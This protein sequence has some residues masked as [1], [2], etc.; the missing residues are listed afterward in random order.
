MTWVNP[1]VIP[2]LALDRRYGQS[3]SLVFHV[4]SLVAWRELL[5]N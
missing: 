4:F 1:F 2:E 5:D 3:P